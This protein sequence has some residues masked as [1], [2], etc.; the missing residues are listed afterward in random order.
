[1]IL[2]C[3]LVSNETVLNRGL[4][5]ATISA[6][7]IG[8]LMTKGEFNFNEPVV[9]VHLPFN[10]LKRLDFG[11]HDHFSVSAKDWSQ[12]RLPLLYNGENLDNKK[13]IVFP[14]HGLGDQMYLDIALRALQS[15]YSNLSITM[16]KPM[17]K[18]IAAWHPYI[19]GHDRVD[20]NGPVIATS[21]MAEYD[22]YVDAEHFVHLPGYEGTYPPLF[23]M[24]SMF[25]HDPDLIV[26]L[27]PEIFRNDP[28]KR[29]LSKKIDD[30]GK[31]LKSVSKPVLFVGSVTTGRVRDLSV[32]ALV[33]FIELANPSYSLIVSTYKR[34]DLDQVLDD[35][36]L[37][38]IIPT[39]GL[40]KSPNDLLDIIELSDYV[41]T[42]D[43]GIT[44]MAEAL[45]KPCASIF[46][47]VSPQER[48]GPYLYSESLMV[49][50]ELPSVCKTPCYFHALEEGALC[51]GMAYMNKHYG[52][53]T[54]YDY[55]P[56]MENLAGHHLKELLDCLVEKFPR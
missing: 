23:Y 32:K 53:M 34:P 1:M 50:F 45:K 30:L 28:E 26:D 36:N 11:E 29:V 21:L 13:L 47:V 2:L 35:L 12:Q 22:Y 4:F 3:P 14:M 38:D 33:E 27:R 42:T 43:S 55:P 44:H 10:S 7:I 56:C 16:V 46:N 40:I 39:A 37:S 54:F 9:P 49:E 19:Y 25:H 51:A 18:T 24:K 41:L 20:F 15:H 8:K 48:I 5:V 17:V 52:D 31:H 6:E